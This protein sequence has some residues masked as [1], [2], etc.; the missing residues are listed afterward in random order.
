M[1]AGEEASRASPEEATSAGAL[2]E[3]VVVA[4]LRLS[5]PPS[6]CR[7]PPNTQR[8]TKSLDW[9]RPRKRRPDSHHVCSSPCRPRLRHNTAVGSVRN[10]RLCVQQSR[11][12]VR[13]RRSVKLVEAAKRAS[14]ASFQSARR[15]QLM[16]LFDPLDQRTRWVGSTL[17]GNGLDSR[18]Y[19]RHSNTLLNHVS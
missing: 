14:T 8:S 2:R 4:F 17:L 16:D 3:D 13:C 15:P 18:S 5:T 1:T 11:F 19:R 12:P 10:S 7:R 6:P 9:R